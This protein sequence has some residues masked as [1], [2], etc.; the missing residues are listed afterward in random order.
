MRLTD[1]RLVV[2][3]TDLA[4]HLACAHLTALDVAVAQGRP[5]PA[6]GGVPGLAAL[7]SSVAAAWGGLSRGCHHHASE[8]PPTRDELLG[9]MEVVEEFQVA[10]A[11]V[12]R[13]HRP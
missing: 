12:A 9:W 6:T 2:S 1:T 10:V 8:I 5:P 3:P 11:R 7:A 13:P 4:N